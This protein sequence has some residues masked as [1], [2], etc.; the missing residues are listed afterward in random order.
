MSDEI[1]E[2]R[3]RIARLEARDACVSTFNQYLHYLDGDFT[4]E[5]LG[6]FAEDAQLEVMNYPPSSGQNLD[7]RGHEEIR[8]LYAQHSGIIA[9]HH[10][11]NVSVNLSPDGQ[12]AE[13]SSYFLTSFNYGVAGGM[14]EARFEPREGR[15]LLCWLRISNTW[16]WAVHQENPPFLADHLGAGTLRGG[17]PVVYELPE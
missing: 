14:Y 12:S 1:A 13:L 7:L 10:A 16:G 4:D 5:I 11:A 2:L 17:H 6:V 9:R 15:W 3:A 8:P